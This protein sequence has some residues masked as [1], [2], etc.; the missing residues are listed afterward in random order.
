MKKQIFHIIVI[1]SILISVHAYAQSSEQWCKDIDLLTSKIEQYHPMPWARISQKEFELKAEEI[2]TKL[3]SWNNEKITLEILKLIASIQD[4]HTQVLLD[5]QDK[6]DLWF[7]VRFEKFEDGLFITGS[8]IKNAE[9]VGARV[10]RIGNYDTESACQIVSEIIATDSDYGIA[11]RITNFLS[12]A[13]VLSK[14]DIIGSNTILPLEILLKD[15]KT[16]KVNLESSEWSL[17]FNWAY[18]K[19]KVPTKSETKIFFGEKDSLPIYLS[20]FIKSPNDP[21]WFQYLPDNRMIYFQL[22]QIFDGSKESL[23]D[24]TRKVLSFYDEKTSTIDKFVI[25]LRFNEGGNGELVSELVREFKQ[26]NNSLDKGKLFIITGNNTFSAASV[27]TGQMLKATNVITVGEIADGPLNFSSDPVMFYLPNS[28]LLV[29]ISRLYSQDGHPTDHRG[30]YPPDYYIFNTS[31]DYFS[32]FDP[33]M[34]AIKGNKV[35]SLKDILYNE[36]FSNF[37]AEFEKRK[38]INGA[39]IRWFPYTSYD[40][41]LYAFNNL[42]PSQKYEEA[43]EISQL[44]TVIYPESIWGW[45]IEGMLYENMG[46]LEEALK[47]FKELLIL[48]PYHIEAK[49]EY[50]KIGAML[51]P[52]IIDKSILESYTGEFEGRKILLEDGQLKYQVGDGK[53]RKLIPISEKYF[54]IE[55]SSYRIVFFN[56]N[57]KAEKIRLIKWDGK[58][59]V[60][61][62]IDLK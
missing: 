24:F 54:L 11:R 17:S 37:K 52:V 15:G 18:D 46:Q 16:R 20:T 19:T 48:E 55:N 32:L 3:K 26:R 36:G 44:N 60:F 50:E 45:F 8:D 43:L 29:N 42:I 57:N 23:L 6:F 21:F 38:K 33:V 10:L 61:K 59:Q 28:N 58:T 41:A 47:C 39:A 5:N 30:Y 51:H 22:N 25:D 13:V 27:F 40:L 14:L 49:W 12:N 9:L 56:T 1:I 4:G 35:K 7:P 62:R 34:E 2:K 53:K 31:K